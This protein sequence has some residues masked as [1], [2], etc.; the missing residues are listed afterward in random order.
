[1][2]RKDSDFLLQEIDR[3]PIFKSKQMKAVV[4]E[5]PLVMSHSFV[6]LQNLSDSADRVVTYFRQPSPNSFEAVSICSELLRVHLNIEMKAFVSLFLTTFHA[7]T[8]SHF[9]N[10]ESQ[11]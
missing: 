3:Y 1:M 6:L 4:R 7:T 8:I 11:I 10:S 5:H 2:S 9:Y